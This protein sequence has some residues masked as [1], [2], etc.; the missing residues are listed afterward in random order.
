MALIG[1]EEPRL[2]TRPL[3]D[4]TPETS[5][6]F[7]AV[8]FAREVLGVELHPWQRWWLIHTL[9]LAPGSFTSDALPELR[10]RTVITEVAR[11]NGKS[12]LLMVRM[13][14]RMFMWDD[15]TGHAPLV[16][17]TA[18]KLS[19]AEEILDQT[20]KIVHRSDALYGSITHRHNTNG[21][22]YFELSNGAR[23]KCEAASDDGGR[24]LTVTDLGFD[25][26]RQ[27]R[28]WSAWAAMSNTTNAV[29]SSQVVGVSNAGEAKST[30]LASL[31]SKG[32]AEIAA[33]AESSGEYVPEDPSLGWFEWSAPDDCSI[34]DRDGWAWSNPS[35]GHPR[36]PTE[37]LLKSRADLVGLPGE[38]IPEAKFR[39]ENLCQWVT[40]MERGPFDDESIEACVDLESVV[41]E[42]SPLVVSVDT[43]RDR[44]VSWVAVAGWRPD[45]V[46]HVEVIARRAF[47]DWV[48]AYLAGKDPG[49]LAFR[50]AATVVQGRGCHASSLIDFIEDADV[51]V[52]RCEGNDLTSACGQFFDRIVQG[53]V[54]FGDEP[55]LLTALREVV[56]KNLG[57]AFV[58]NRDKSPVDVAPLCAATFALWGLVHGVSASAPK[59]TAYGSD[60]GSWWE[61]V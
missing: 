61:G 7:E 48:P 53:T 28:D 40:A 14:W 58:W 54:R 36:G 55:A 42:A 19:L 6:G 9:E 18:H 35:L 32:L 46:P 2:W 50:P 37:A 21:D 3:R 44:S 31:R 57:D 51:P 11:Q 1:K 52:T 26:L 30:V 5:F 43:A 16:L 29:A 23:Y 20:V 8:A 45:G 25:E 27:Q 12:F 49:T 22:K 59:A 24:G 38:G 41:D 33:W 56:V 17:G 10:F 4:L 34:W 60:Y 39:T 15:G 13:L 47:T